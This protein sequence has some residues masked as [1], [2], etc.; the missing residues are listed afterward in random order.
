MPRLPNLRTTDIGKKESFTNVEVIRLPVL[1]Y[2]ILRPS[3]FGIRSCLLVSVSLFRL[4]LKTDSLNRIDFKEPVS[5]GL[6]T[7]WRVMAAISSYTHSL[8]RT[9][10]TD[11]YRIFTKY[12]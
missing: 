4:R 6:P 5:F 9:K 8:Q 12:F 11:I 7:R 2:F 10:L 3:V 1:Q